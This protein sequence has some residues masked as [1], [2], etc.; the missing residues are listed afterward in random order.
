MSPLDDELRAAL[1][2]RA[3]SVLPSP[4]PLVGA[5]RRAAGLRRRRTAA[6]VVG[7]ALA[8]AAIAVAVPALA[9]SSTGP[10]P[11]VAAS[12]PPTAVVQAPEALDPDAPWPY[13]GAPLPQLGDGFLDAA[14]TQYAALRGVPET[15]VRLTPLFGQVHEPSGTSELVVLAVVDGQPSWRVVVSSES[16][17][18]VRVDEPLPAPGTRP[19]IGVDH[20]CARPQPCP[21][22]GEVVHHPPADRIADG[23]RAAAGRGP[24]ATPSTDRGQRPLDQLLGGGPVAGE[25]QGGAQQLRAP[26]GDEL[27]ERRV[28][29]CPSCTPARV[30]HR[31][32]GRFSGTRRPAGRS[33][34][35]AAPRGSSPAPPGCGAGRTSARSPATRRGSG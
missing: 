26:G 32:P 31:C 19:G 3:G 23:S 10:A 27:L 12:A 15:A 29:R 2:S 24:P 22:T 16:G 11:Q 7:S 1:H 34:R 21:S 28:H 18:E 30:R 33:P 4:D 9:P 13:R 17:P 35:R 25:Q 14:T 5:E 20:L 6:S 8:A